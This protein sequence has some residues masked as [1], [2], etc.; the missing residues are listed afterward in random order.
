MA[1]EDTTRGVPRSQSGMWSKSEVADC[2]MMKDT[3]MISSW[4]LEEL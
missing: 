1:D 4:R 2:M 3:D